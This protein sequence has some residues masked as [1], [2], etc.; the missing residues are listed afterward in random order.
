MN[1]GVPPTP[2]NAR[3]G[4]L[5]PPG[6]TFRARSNMAVDCGYLSFIRS[7]GRWFV[8][9]RESDR[10]GHSLQTSCEKSR[11]CGMIHVTPD[12]PKTLGQ[13]LCHRAT[14]SQREE[15]K[16]TR[17]GG[18]KEKERRGEEQSDFLL[19]LSP[20]PCPLVPLSPCSPPSIC[21]VS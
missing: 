16:G 12:Q 3:T 7:S 17:R 11:V 21:C 10:A 20:S 5:T 18:D 15:D 2:R 8:L 9:M 13:Y 1:R 6:I 4:L 14:E 19:S